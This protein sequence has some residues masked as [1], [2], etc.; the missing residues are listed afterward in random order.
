[1]PASRGPQVIARTAEV[2]RA[3]VRIDPR[4]RNE[5]G[6]NLT[7]TVPTP[8][9]QPPPPSEEEFYTLLKK[10]SSQDAARQ[11]QTFV[12]HLLTEH[13]SLEIIFTPN[14]LRMKVQPRGPDDSQFVILAVGINGRIRTTK[15]WLDFLA[16][17]SPESVFN[18]FLDGLKAIDPRLRPLTKPNGIFLV[19]KSTR[20]ADLTSIVPKL[21]ALAEVVSTAVRTSGSG[22]PE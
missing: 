11:L 22:T 5:A 3:V 16:E 4:V 13:E 9:D 19:P 8:D 6:V 1:M 15:Q 14:Q 20:A 17:H 7:V 18:S 21:D 10:S 2:T 12:E